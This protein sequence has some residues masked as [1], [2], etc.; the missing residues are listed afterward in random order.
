[1]PRKE[2][3][4]TVEKMGGRIT[5]SVSKNTD[6]VIVGKDPGSKYDKA[7]DLNIEIIDENKLKDIINM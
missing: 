4:E 3:K 1:M 2:I 7:V 5:G 6:F